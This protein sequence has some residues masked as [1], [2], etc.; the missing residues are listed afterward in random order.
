MDMINNIVFAGEIISEMYQVRHIHL[1][2]YN[3]KF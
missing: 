3:F 2:C 1:K